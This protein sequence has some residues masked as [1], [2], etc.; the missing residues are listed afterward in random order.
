MKHRI[1]W[2][3]SL[4][5]QR[6]NKKIHLTT[7]FP[8]ITERSRREQEMKK[9]C[10]RRSKKEQK[11]FSQRHAEESA[12]DRREPAHNPLEAMVLYHPAK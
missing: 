1:V 11:N 3:L 10:F 2:V 5:G 12:D 9:C 4:D 7:E 8:E 6:K